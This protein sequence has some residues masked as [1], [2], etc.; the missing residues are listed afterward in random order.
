MG[1]RYAARRVS[2][3][4]L[5]LIALLALP[6]AV[7]LTPLL[8]GEVLVGRDL[9]AYFYPRLEVLGEALGRGEL[10]RWNPL[11]GH[12]ASWF[13]P[14]GAGVLYPG[15]LLFAVF[16]SRV[17]MTLFMLGHVLIAVLGA[18]RL[19]QVSGCSARAADA[20]GI[21]YGLGGFVMSQIP[22]PLYLVSGALLPWAAVAGL[23]VGAAP[24][25]AA[26]TLGLAIGLTLLTV[27]PQG[28]LL[29]ALL[30]LA[31]ASLGGD[32]RRRRWV[33][34]ALGVA[35]GAAAAGPQLL[36]IL[37]EAPRT[38]RGLTLVDQRWGLAGRGLALQLLAP[39]SLGEF[40]IGA[41]ATWGVALWDGRTPWCGITIGG[42]GLAAC[43][44]ALADR[45]PKDAQAR[46]IATALI[47][48]GLLL[49]GFKPGAPL[50]LRFSAKWLVLT[51]L[52]AA[53]AVGLGF[54]R[55]ERGEGRGFLPRTLAAL[56]V[57]A[58]AGLLFVVVGGAELQQTLADLAPGRVDGAAASE[59]L[60][61]AFVRALALALLGLA[62]WRRALPWRR[63]QVLLFGLLAL[64]LSLAAHAS[65]SATDAP[66]LTRP[67]LVDV[68]AKEPA[69]F[70]ALPL[71]YAARP[72]ELLTQGWLQPSERFDRAET[73]DLFLHALLQNGACYRYGI[74]DVRPFESVHARAV[75]E[76]E[77]DPAFKALPR[78]LQ[79]ALFDAQV[80]PVTR[81]EVRASRGALTPV[82]GI[83]ET[84]GV[85]RNQVCP[86]WAYL[87]RQG[88]LKE[89]AA[90]ARALLLD[91]GRAPQDLVVLGPRRTPADVA[92]PNDGTWRP[93]A[94]PLGTV[95]AIEF[96]PERIALRASCPSL[97][98]LVVREAFSPDWTCTVD[99][100]PAA[101]LQ[102]DLLYRAVV[103]PPGEHTVVFTYT[104][105]WWAPGLALFALGWLAILALW[106][107][108]RGSPDPAAR[109]LGSANE[110]PDP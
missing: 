101:Q 22:I 26:A 15:N 33:W 95:S 82:I 63:T 14:R 53:W 6:V 94:D 44:A 8:L 59:A 75:G 66:V 24:K 70:E 73:R 25:R 20:T 46:W 103:L 3:P 29:M 102:A 13:G 28:A 62:V 38:D 18:R 39:G 49:A 97:R 106:L 55:W 17:A 85:A 19:A 64:E 108:S 47:V 23:T 36:S 45:S 99:G 60:R 104:P 88:R 50:G 37:D 58:G 42:V 110:D 43:L 32:G 74:R 93:R 109:A 96:G 90:A 76:L 67:P 48:G 9:L 78:P 1:Q 71:R 2:R 92:V 51:A 4:V 79:L 83:N 81:D 21:A 65:L 30:A 16:S 7:F 40:R 31:L 52:G 91:P 105:W 61:E 98:I 27:E 57:F 56:A 11:S 10:P 77:R 89:D 72:Q 84:I 41:G 35:L 34:V 86:P 100:A 107:R 69:Q 87:V 68:L 5:R 54:S 12:G 80:A